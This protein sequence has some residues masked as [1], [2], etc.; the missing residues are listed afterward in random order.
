MWRLR[1]GSLRSLLRDDV[2]R[3]QGWTMDRMVDMNRGACSLDL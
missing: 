1:L 3:D 2:G